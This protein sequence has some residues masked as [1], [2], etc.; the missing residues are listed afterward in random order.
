MERTVRT[1]AIAGQGPTCALASTRR[2]ARL[3]TQLY[4]SY[5]VEHGVESAQYA[6]MMMVDAA[7]DKGQAAMGKA[8]GMD[9][10]TL[11][12]NLRVLRARGWVE[13][14]A[15]K[16]A[17][18]RSIALTGEGRA[19]LVRARPAWKRA[20][21]GLRSGMSDREWE[22]MWSS[23]RAMAHAVGAAA[24]KKSRLKGE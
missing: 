6:L 14:V 5:L 19:L 21:A 11:S 23:L 16:D 18:Q 10:T 20:Q 15:G 4:D 8:L 24:E 3:L 17:R 9:K 2:M 12:R 1:D 13:S 7:E 22:G